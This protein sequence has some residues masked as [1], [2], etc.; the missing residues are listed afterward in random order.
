MLRSFEHSL[1]SIYLFS[2]KVVQTSIGDLLKG[3]VTTTGGTDFD[4]I[5]ESIVEKSLDRAVI[6]TDGYASLKQ[7]WKDALL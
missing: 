6:L 7:E 5:A 3:R 2:N 1:L 4:C